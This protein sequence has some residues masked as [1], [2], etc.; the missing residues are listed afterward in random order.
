MESAAGKRSSQQRIALA[1]AGG[2]P[3][4]T[5]DQQTRRDLLSSAGTLTP[6]LQRHSVRLHHERLRDPQRT[7]ESSARERHGK[8]AVI[9]ELQRTLAE[10]SV[11]IHRSA[12]PALLPLLLIDYA[13]FRFNRRARLV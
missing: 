3:L 6:L 13:G 9:V 10:L 7:F 8:A 2:G 5:F 11:W 1:L 4:G 12:W